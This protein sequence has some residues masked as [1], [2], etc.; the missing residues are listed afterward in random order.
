VALAIDRKADQMRVLSDL[1]G[2]VVGAVLDDEASGSDS[3]A[4]TDALQR[5]R[6]VGAPDL[7]SW[8]SAISDAS[9][10]WRAAQVLRHLTRDLLRGLSVAGDPAAEET[11][12]TAGATPPPN[13]R[14]IGEAREVPALELAS[15][16]T[17]R[18]SGPALTPLEEVDTSA[19]RRSVVSARSRYPAIAKG[20]PGVLP[21]RPRFT[22]ITAPPPV[23]AAPSVTTP[24]APV[25]VAPAP[26][27]GTAPEAVMIAPPPIAPP[28]AA[29]APTVEQESVIKAV[30][31]GID[32]VAGPFAR[33]QQLAAFVK[34]LRAV[35]G[36]QDVTTRQFVRGMVHLRVRHSYDVALAD[37]LLELAEFRPSIVSN[38]QDRIELKVDLAE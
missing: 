27:T 26:A 14:D 16:G 12:E 37:R 28:L 3:D 7:G 36:V 24:S 35:A 23:A 4:F 5:Y 22:E 10:G 33:F 17:W 6:E 18:P 38:T 19:L 1:S 8:R 25:D 30:A 11:A 20:E 9:S 29:P 32:I 15:D 21:A 34:A 13:V 31:G 2:Y